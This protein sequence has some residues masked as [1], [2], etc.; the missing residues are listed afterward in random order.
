MTLGEFIIY[1][2]DV[3]MKNHFG[4]E[5]WLNIAKA[6]SHLIDDNNFKIFYDVKTSA[7]KNFIREKGVMI[8]LINEERQMGQGYRDIDSND[9]SSDLILDTSGDLRECSQKFLDIAQYIVQ[10]NKD[11]IIYT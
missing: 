3:V 6:S 2:A 10:H 7:E 9:E 11:A 1:F 4:K 8:Q 5:I